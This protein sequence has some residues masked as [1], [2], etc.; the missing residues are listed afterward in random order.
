[1]LQWNTEAFLAE[2]EVLIEVPDG[3]ILQFPFAVTR[4][5]SVFDEVIDQ[6]LRYT[7][8]QED[9]AAG[10]VKWLQQKHIGDVEDHKVLVDT[11]VAIRKLVA[12]GRNHIW[13]Y[14]T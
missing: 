1:S 6:V 10:L 13:G 5:P 4:D 11:C 3:P 14:I 2:R 12:E 7:A 8:G 9:D